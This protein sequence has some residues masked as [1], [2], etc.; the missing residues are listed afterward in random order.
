MWCPEIIGRESW[1][2]VETTFGTVRTF[3]PQGGGVIWNRTQ[4]LALGETD[5]P[6]YE[7]IVV[8][9]VVVESY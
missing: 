9:V 7:I 4:T 1:E 6:C 8:V 2:W 5:R 3:P